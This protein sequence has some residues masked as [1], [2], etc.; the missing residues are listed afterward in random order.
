MDFFNVIPYAD[1]VNLL[2]GR[3]AAVSVAETISVCDAV[4][5][6]SSEDIISPENLPS[7]DK[8]IVDGFAVKALDTCG[9]SESIPA[10]LDV[11]GGVV[12]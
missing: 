1:A 10:I 12:M 3:L 6:I 8:S 7:F 2:Q 9:A 5:R 4:G 11:L